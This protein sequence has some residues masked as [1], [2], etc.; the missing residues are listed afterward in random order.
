[1]VA[2][3]RIGGMCVSMYG[4]KP[5]KPMCHMRGIAQVMHALATCRSQSSHSGSAEMA[6]CIHPARVASRYPEGLLP[7]H[8]HALA[9]GVFLPSHILA[10]SLAGSRDDGYLRRS[11]S[12]VR[13]KPFFK[14]GLHPFERLM[15]VGS[16][17]SIG[18]HGHGSA[19]SFGKVQADVPWTQ[20][21][22]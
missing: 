18:R 9:H 17:A 4:G 21:S 19:R 7:L 14:M 2:F 15:G 8:I 5:P 3:C 1:M 12:D 10:T 16:R 11:K 20:G 22:Q 6:V 13:S